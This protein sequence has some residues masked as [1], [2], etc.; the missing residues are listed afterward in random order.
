M[1]KE[2]GK[3]YKN[4][5]NEFKDYNSIEEYIQDVV[6][7]LMFSSWNYSEERAWDIIKEREDYIKEAYD[8]KEPAND[9]CAEVGYHCG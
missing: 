8:N 6:I 3:R 9:C 4:E 2:D 5:C 7:C 1:T